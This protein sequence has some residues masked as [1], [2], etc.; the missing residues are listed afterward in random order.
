MPTNNLLL[1]PITP[2][3]GTPVA[4]TNAPAAPAKSK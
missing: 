1:P 3:P 2:P 4:P